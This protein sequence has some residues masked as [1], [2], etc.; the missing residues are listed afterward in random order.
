MLRLNF[1]RGCAE[2]WPERV[3]S[4]IYSKDAKEQAEKSDT[5]IAL[6]ES[7]SKGEIQC[8]D[9]TLNGCAVILSKPSRDASKQGVSTPYRLFV[10]QIPWFLLRQKTGWRNLSEPIQA[11]QRAIQRISWTV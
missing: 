3:H 8:G 1:L 2:G 7:L 6:K 9:G 11:F 5:T 10:I 4:K